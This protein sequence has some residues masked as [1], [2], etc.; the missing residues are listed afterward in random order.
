MC[1]SIAL[2]LWL[3]TVDNQ[4]MWESVEGISRVWASNQRPVW[5]ELGEP[6]SREAC[7]GRPRGAMWEDTTAL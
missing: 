1:N 4:H 6:G 7:Q 3:S 2:R 5:L